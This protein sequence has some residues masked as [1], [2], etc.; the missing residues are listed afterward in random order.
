MEDE[1][2]MSAPKVFIVIINWNGTVDTIECLNSVRDIQYQNYN[3]IV[4]DNFSEIESVNQIL[5]A[6]PWIK[7]I[8]NNSNLGFAEGNNI[9]IKYSLEHGA[10]YIL[11]L[12]ND[13]TIKSDF[14]EPLVTCMEKDKDIAIAGPIMCYYD[15]PGIVWQTGGRFISFLGR[16][17]MP[18]A[19]QSYK[20]IKEDYISLDY[21]PGAGL[22]VRT[23]DLEYLGLLDKNFFNQCEDLDWGLKAKR[24][25][26]KVICVKRSILYH[27][28]SGSTPSFLKNYFR[29]R[30]QLIIVSRYSTRNF[31]IP[32]I[33]WLSVA[34]SKILKFTY[35]GHRLQAYAIFLGI[36]DYYQGNFGPGSIDKLLQISKTNKT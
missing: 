2:Y 13:T 4:V 16:L 8:R 17:S 18:Y 21:L 34:L 22:L 6:H 12:N 24:H 9:G 20:M 3:V 35:N 29:F 10:E 32:Q 1:V 30:N 14:L 26:K 33:Y 15:N 19:G 23:S 31:F 25:G 36:I 11:L 7:L 28:V 27:K 5:V